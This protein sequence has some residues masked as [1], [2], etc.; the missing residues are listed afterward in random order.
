MITKNTGITIFVFIVCAVVSFVAGMRVGGPAYFTED[1]VYRAILKTGTLSQLRVG[2]SDAALRAMEG[3]LDN[4]LY[5]YATESGGYASLV[6]PDLIDEERIAKYL[7]TIAEYRRQYPY[8]YLKEYGSDM[9]QDEQD[10]IREQQEVIT[11]FLEGY[12]E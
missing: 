4:D 3:L 10:L 1:A 5:L 11:K 9:S 7:E 12:R 6:F 2:N 8:D